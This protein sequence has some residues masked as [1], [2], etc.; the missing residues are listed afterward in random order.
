MMRSENTENKY[1]FSQNELKK[2]SEVLLI[3]D[4]FPVCVGVWSLW[5][6]CVYSEYM[7]IFPLPQLPQP[8]PFSR[9]KPPRPVALVGKW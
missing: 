7:P 8:H 9:L 3:V 6:V 5:C 4:F 1:H 2:Q